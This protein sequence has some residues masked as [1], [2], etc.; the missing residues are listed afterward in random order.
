MER[1]RDILQ[2][3]YARLA[4]EALNALTPEELRQVYG[5]FA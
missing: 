4:P 2:D 5:C 3:E 1:N